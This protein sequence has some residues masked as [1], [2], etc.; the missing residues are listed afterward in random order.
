MRFSTGTYL[1][2]S[3]R[4]LRAAEKLLETIKESDDVPFWSL[5]SGEITTIY[6]WFLQLA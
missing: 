2:F 1:N 6:H 3:I 5:V 4:D